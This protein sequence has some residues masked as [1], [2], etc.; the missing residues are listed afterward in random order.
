MIFLIEGINSTKLFM[1]A[2]HK[3]IDLLPFHQLKKYFYR[4]DSDY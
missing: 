1:D 2:L 3:L 4:F